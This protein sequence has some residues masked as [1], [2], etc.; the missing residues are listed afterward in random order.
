[1]RHLL[2][3]PRGPHV[4]EVQHF[5]ASRSL[6]KPDEG[7][8][9]AQRAKSS[10]SSAPETRTRHRSICRFEAQS[11]NV[12]VDFPLFQRMA[13]PV[14]AGKTKIAGIGIHDTRMMRLME[15]LL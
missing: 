12:H 10:G 3:E 4:P 5:P 8:S 9:A 15:V 14:T 1:M 6:R 13:L 2:Q 7:P 11:L